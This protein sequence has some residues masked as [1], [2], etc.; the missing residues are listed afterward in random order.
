MSHPEPPAAEDGF[1][2]GME[3]LLVG[4]WCCGLNCWGLGA[5]GGKRC[6]GLGCPTQGE[7]RCPHRV[8]LWGWNGGMA[9]VTLLPRGWI[10]P[11]HCSWSELPLPQ[12]PHRG[13]KPHGDPG[14]QP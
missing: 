6:A 11:S 13:R 1:Q 2:S 3:V 7:H 5:W 8:M 9:N 4:Q 10:S 12:W 14:A